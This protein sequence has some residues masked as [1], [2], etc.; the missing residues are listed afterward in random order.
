V[1]EMTL[2]ATL[3]CL[4]MLSCAA[5]ISGLKGAK[6]SPLSNSEQLA[7]IAATS[8]NQTYAL[9]K[10]V[11]KLQIMPCAVCCCIYTVY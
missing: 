5:V 4:S 2:Y 11:D 10:A 3:Y 8:C 1:Q 6:V 9:K 7:T